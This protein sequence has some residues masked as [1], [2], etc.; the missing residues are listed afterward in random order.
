MSIAVSKDRTNEDEISSDDE[1][2]FVL[3]YKLYIKTSDGVLL[4]AKW[5]K[6]SVSIINELLL[7]IHNKIYLITKDTII[8]PN[9]YCVIFKKQRE[10]VAGTQLADV[11][12]FIKFKSECTKLAA[13]N[14][15]NLC[16]NS[17][18]DDN[19][20][21]PPDYK[22]N[23]RIPS[24]SSL[25]S[26]NKEIA[27]NILQ[28]REAHHCNI[29]NRPCLNKE[30]HSDLHVEINFMMLSVWASDMSN[31][32]ITSTLFTMSEF[33]KELDEKE[34][35]GH[36]YQNFLE[37]FETQQILVRYLRRLTD[38]QFDKCEVKTISAQQTL[39]EYA[40]KLQ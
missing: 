19:A 30:K 34:E 11:Q 15:S 35:T 14:N 12:D 16:Y 31:S 36:Y 23:N 22:N 24:I 9:D 5:L 38:E 6:E 8:M 7:S 40:E 13:K 10:A 3:D 33:L 21:R 26:Y 4:P 29:H 2:E 27:E 28:I 18:E 25:S 17:N 32:N 20:S 1:S 37:E 39:R